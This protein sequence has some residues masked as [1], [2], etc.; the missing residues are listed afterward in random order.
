MST[1]AKI[2]ELEKQINLL[3][4]QL[5]SVKA[6]LEQQNT[7]FKVQLEQQNKQLTEMKTEFA[8]DFKLSV[9]LYKPPEAYSPPPPINLPRSRKIRDVDSYY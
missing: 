5:D 6:Q 8:D 9:R 4:V 1:D 2:S 3:K 7:F